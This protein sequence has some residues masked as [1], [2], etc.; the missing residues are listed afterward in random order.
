M[1]LLPRALPTGFI[2]PCLPTSAPRPPSGD[3]WLQEIK[4]DGFRVI[5]REPRN[6]IGQRTGSLD[7]AHR[8]V[9]NVNDLVD[10]ALVRTGLTR[11]G[12]IGCRSGRFF[13]NAPLGRTTRPD[14][15]HLAVRR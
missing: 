14:R 5:A 10:A 15:A 4:H 7:A 6:R 2:A 12:L 3:L 1:S 13:V 11:R 9:R 8:G